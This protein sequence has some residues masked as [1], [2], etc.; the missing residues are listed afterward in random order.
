MSFFLVCTI[1]AKF[2]LP[3]EFVEIPSGSFVMGSPLT[4]KDRGKEEQEHIVMLKSF[5]MSKYEITFDQYDTYCRAV[6]KP[7]IYDEEWGRA[8]RP[9]IHVTWQDATDFAKWM[10]CRLPT[11][12]EWEYACRAETKTA[13]SLG[14][15][16]TSKEVNF[17]G[18]FPYLDIAESEYRE[19]TLP[20]GSFEPN[21]FGLHDMH[22]NVQ[23]WCSDWCGSYPTI[24]EKNPAGPSNGVYKVVRGG[25]WFSSAFNCR[26][27]CRD[28]STPDES[29]V[30]IGIRLV[31]D[32]EYEE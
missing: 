16:I 32:E 7:L 11:E 3:I 1:S 20:V 19:M 9:I 25:S 26:S 18:K 22:G 15:N 12:A 29:T 10:G 17:N 2:R 31:A 28:S 21:A 30:D 23:E 6:G 5:K 4:E 8:K 13:Y 27:A 14:E 24:A